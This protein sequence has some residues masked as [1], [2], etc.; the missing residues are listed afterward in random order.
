VNTLTWSC[1]LQREYFC[2]LAQIAAALQCAT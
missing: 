1:R 2:M